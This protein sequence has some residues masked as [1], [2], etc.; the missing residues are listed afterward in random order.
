M[1]LDLPVCV[2]AGKGIK[3]TISDI[4][5]AMLFQ[6]ENIVKDGEKIPLPKSI[7]DHYDNA[8]YSDGVWIYIDLDLA[9]FKE[10]LREI[11]MKVSTSVSTQIATNSIV[12]FWESAS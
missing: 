11:W 7:D 12:F 4:K 8:N 10:H 2:G 5:S 6:M 9:Q 1:A 3:N